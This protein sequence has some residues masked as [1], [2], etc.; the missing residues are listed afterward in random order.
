MAKSVN[1]DITDATQAEGLRTLE[2]NDG[3]AGRE[4]IQARRAV[5]Q[6]ERR[7]SEAVANA[8]SG[9]YSWSAVGSLLGV[10]RQAAQQRFGSGLG[11]EA[12]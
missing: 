2:V 6:A 10:S 11:K 9:G 5:A 7:L 3:A 1:S 8:R 4:I 12:S